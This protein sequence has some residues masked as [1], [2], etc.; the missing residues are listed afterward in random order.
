MDVAQSL[1]VLALALCGAVIVFLIVREVMCW[2]WKINDL[3]SE[4]KRSNELQAEI[5]AVL[6][7]AKAAEPTGSGAPPRRAPARGAVR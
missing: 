3:L 2:Y 4:V 1:G 5:L 6:R 7:G